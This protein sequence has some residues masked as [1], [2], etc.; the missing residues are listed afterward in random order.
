[1][2]PEPSEASEKS[3][4]KSSSIHH[5]KP[6]AIDVFFLGKNHNSNFNNREILL[7]LLC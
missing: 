4:G 2:Q 3:S 7:I 1:M 5:F 6:T